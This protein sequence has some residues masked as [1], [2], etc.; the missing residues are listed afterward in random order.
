MQKNTERK[1]RETERERERERERESERER[2]WKIFT[3]ER[4]VKEPAVE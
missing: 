3:G 1:E 2:G 4:K